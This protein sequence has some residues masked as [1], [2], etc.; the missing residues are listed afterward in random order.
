MKISRAVP[1]AGLLAVSLVLGAC[2]SDSNDNNT[3]STTNAGTTGTATGTTGTTGSTGTTTTTTGTVNSVAAIK[4]ARTGA[5]ES[6]SAELTAGYYATAAA[7]QNATAPATAT[8]LGAYGQV[9]TAADNTATNTRVQL[10]NLETYV[11]SGGK[12]SRVQYSNQVRGAFYNAAYNGDAQACEL[13]TCL[14]AESSGGVSVKMTAGKLFRFWPEA[15]FTQSLVKPAQVEAI[16]TT[17]QT[18]LVQDTAGGADDRANAKYLVNTAAAWATDAWVQSGTANGS[19]GAYSAALTDVGNGQLRLATNDW[20]AVNFTT[21]TDTQVDE[22]GVAPASGR[23][24]I[25]NSADNDDD[26]VRIMYIGD[27]ITQGSAPQAGTAQDSFRRNL[28]NGLMT[29]ASLPQVDF[30]GTRLGTSTADVNSC[31]NNTTAVD[32]GVYKLPEFDTA[33]QGYWGA[34]VDQVNTALPQA[35]ATLKA[36]V[37]DQEPDVAVIH[38]GTNNLHND[39]ANG[40]ANAVTQ[41]RA[42]I[43][44]LRAADDDITILVAQV[45]PYLNTEGGTE[46]ASVAAYNAQIVSQI[47]PLSTAKSK[48]V[49]VDQ[50]AGFATTMLRDRFHPNDQGEAVI[51]DKWLAALKSNNLLKD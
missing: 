3:A 49:V 12:W 8:A 42:M 44:T 39:A 22:L 25:A 34:C 41:L 14:R 19:T 30:V 11:R 33:H 38:I 7:A 13:G 15:A 9:F 16:F 31:A 4:A 45:I 35:L 6:T 27:S 24:P 23:A 48:V 18:R 26:V 21:A 5:H 40:V 37:R 20:K 50:H 46:E 2:G 17:A 47:A 32:T 43:E 36:A 29:D 1:T 10:R 51:A 28:W